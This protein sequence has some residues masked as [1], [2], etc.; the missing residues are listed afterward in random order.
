MQLTKIH[1]IR[2]SEK[3]AESLNILRNYNVNVSQ[4]IRQAI[5]EKIKLPF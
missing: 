2:F 4:F 5:K 3:Q 1:T